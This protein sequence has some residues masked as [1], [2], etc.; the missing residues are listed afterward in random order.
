[1]IVP[2]TGE[3]FTGPQLGANPVDY[4]EYYRLVRVHLLIEINVISV[5][6]VKIFI[7]LMKYIISLHISLIFSQW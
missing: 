6:L 5:K 7:I 1:M 4:E 2:H 3:C